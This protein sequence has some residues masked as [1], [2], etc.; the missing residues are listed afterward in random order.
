[1]TRWLKARWFSFLGRQRLRSLQVSSALENFRKAAELEPDNLYTATQIGW[2]LYK[3]RNY[4]AAID[5][6]ERA[7]Q[8]QP[9]YASAHACLGLA[10]AALDR[11]NEAISPLKRAIELRPDCVQAHDYLG[12][13]YL[14]MVTVNKRWN[15][16][17][18]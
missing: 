7:L 11:S 12:T 2:C 4:Q 13:A 10:L 1:L 8:Q 5:Q 17:A 16:S 18:F 14:K 6:H 15:N 3:L 9:D